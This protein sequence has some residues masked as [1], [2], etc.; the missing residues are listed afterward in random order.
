[1]SIVQR[2]G[3]KAK[4]TDKFCTTIGDKFFSV[5]LCILILACQKMDLPTIDPKLEA[6][7]PTTVSVP[8]EEESILEARYIDNQGKVDKKK[9][10]VWESENPNIVS[11]ETD[12]G[13]ITAKEAGTTNVKASAVTHMGLTISIVFT[14]KV[15]KPPIKPELELSSKSIIVKIDSEEAI[16]ITYSFVDQ[17]GNPITPSDV[18]WELEGIDDEVLEV[19]EDGSITLLKPGIANVKLTVSFEGKEYSDFVEIEVRQE[20]EI[21]INNPNS[22]ILIGSDSIEQ[23]TVN[24]FNELGEEVEVDADSVVW[25]SENHEIITIDSATGIITPVTLGKATIHVSIQIEDILYTNSIELEVIREIEI[26]HPTLPKQLKKGQEIVQL[27]N[28]IEFI[29]K[30]GGKVSPDS[31]CWESSDLEI[32][33][34]D[35]DGNLNPQRAGNVQISLKVEV[36]GE[37]YPKIVG[38]IKVIQDPEIRITKASEQIRTTEEGRQLSYQYT[39]KNGKVGYS[40][41]IKIKWDSSNRESLDINSFGVLL[42][43]KAGEVIIS[44]TAFQDQKEIAKDQVTF[45][46][47]QPAKVEFVNPPKQVSTGATNKTQLQVRYT[48]EDGEVL[49]PQKISFSSE[50]DGILRINENGEITA[51]G[52]GETKI[53]VR[54]GSD[55]PEDTITIE[56]KEEIDPVLVIDQEDQTLQKGES[57]IV[58]FRYTDKNGNIPDPQ[59]TVNWKVNRN[60]IINYNPDTGEVVA[61]SAGVVTLSITY[62]SVADEIILKVIVEPELVVTPP[63]NPLQIG[64]D[65]HDLKPVFTNELKKD[66]TFSRR[67]QYTEYN[68]EIININSKGIISPV[69]VGTTKVTISTSYVGQIYQETIVIEVVSLIIAEIPELEVGGDTYR[70]KATFIDEKGQSLNPK[71]EWSSSHYNISGGK[72]KPTQ[73]GLSESIRASYRYK[74]GTYTATTTAS[75]RGEIA[76]SIDYF[77]NTIVIPQYGNETENW[78][79]ILTDEWGHTVSDETY[80]VSWNSDDNDIAKINSQGELIPISKGTVTITATSNYEDEI[81]ED[82]VE[83][84]IEQPVLVLTGGT[85]NGILVGDRLSFGYSFTNGGSGPSLS[86]SDVHWN[87]ADDKGYF[88]PQ[89]VG[90]PT[91]SV[92]VYY[93][94]HQFEDS[95][96]L[97]VL[98]LRITDK[99]PN[100]SATIGESKPDLDFEFINEDN[101]EV[102]SASGTWSLKDSSYSSVLTID[103]ATGLVT[104]AGK[105]KATVIL[106]VRYENKIFTTEYEI[107]IKSPLIDVDLNSAKHEQSDFVW[108]AMNYWYLWQSEVPLL[109]DSKAVSENEYKQLIKD[110]PSATSFFNSMLHRNDPYSK[111]LSRSELI[112]LTT[113]SNLSHGMEYVILRGV[114]NTNNNRVGLVLYTSP[115]SNADGKVSRGDYFSHVNGQRLTSS[116]WRSLM[117]SSSLSLRMVEVVRNGGTFMEVDL[118]TIARINKEQYTKNPILV[119]KIVSIGSHKIGYLAYDSFTLNSNDLNSVFKSFK[120]SNI[121]DLVVDLRYNPGGIINT[122]RNLGSMISGLGPNDI[123]M[124][125]L[126]NSKVGGGSGTGITFRDYLDVAGTKPIHKVNVSRV[127]V[128]TGRWTYSASELII[129]CLRPYMDVIQIGGKTGGKNV[130][131]LLLYDHNDHPQHYYKSQGNI[132]TNHNLHLLPIVSRTANSQG[133]SAYENGFTANS[134]NFPRGEGTYDLKPLGDPSEILFS[135]AIEIITGQ[136]SRRAIEDISS[137][138]SVI[139]PRPQELMIDLLDDFPFEIQQ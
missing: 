108:K 2:E 106:T 58:S 128:L 63:K 34:I 82:E 14:V 110:N 16:S 112:S 21:R 87:S 113:G 117:G 10:I 71:V 76:F 120:D 51:V 27:G 47:K 135:R 103:P 102:T 65:V 88:I 6:V 60:D 12:T 44:I 84:E 48:N 7:S 43:K 90:S 109:S 45:K 96:T 137:H 37:I 36:E 133:F 56:V 85:N 91:V 61:R 9:I 93:R 41:L 31:V 78:S 124:I 62:E 42:P 73:P 32:L 129:N 28:N 118:G 114:G 79:T 64:R 22:E 134:G 24:F 15:P 8:L 25:E 98:D 38:S 75:V 30:N 99:P 138:P 70:L 92:S 20:P 81:Y 35:C 33:S 131:S 80:Q 89:E 72:L 119:S 18:K 127:F 105:G 107:T 13:K 66:R 95:Q 116:N 132:N 68:D 136:R 11:V 5:L 54:I 121:T 29:N 59:P 126:Y 139:S 69:S 49:E 1:M 111:V 57:L 97:K 55:G 77:D 115:G 19:T 94:G 40:N 26:L 39:D 23:L 50:D 100:N 83:I 104:P 122:A 125:H 46:V 74:G 130:A 86:P 101:D 67:I 3:L 17:E 52:I 53:T 4:Q 123:F